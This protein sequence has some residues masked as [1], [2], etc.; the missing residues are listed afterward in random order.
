MRLNED[1]LKAED[2]AQRLPLSIITGGAGTGKTTLIESIA[3]TLT[4]KGETVALACPTGKA[5]ARLRESTKRNTSTL[6]R[7]MG[8][9]GIGFDKAELTSMSVI[10]D[11]ASMCDSNLMS[12]VVKRKP[13]RLVL[14]GDEAQLMPVDSGAPFHDLVRLKPEITTNLKICYRNSEAVFQAAMAVRNGEQ[15]PPVI[16]SDK[17]H[18]EFVCLRNVNDLQKYVEEIVKTIDFERDIIL[19]PK[20]GKTT[21]V[22]NNEFD[23][24]ENDFG[25]VKTINEMVISRL[26]NR[27][28]KQKW[29]VGD[30]II[31]LKNFSSLDIWNGTTG[32]VTAIISSGR[33]KGNLIVRGDIPFLSELTG[34]YVEEIEW[35]NDVMQE[36]QHAYALTIHKSQGSQYDKVYF[37]SRAKDQYMFTRPLIYTA[38]TRARKECRVIGD[39]FAMA[40]GISKTSEKRTVIQELSEGKTIATFKEDKNCATS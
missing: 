13:S 3:N 25:T 16:H 35:P 5:A 21:K 33:Q 38:L 10:I 36:C 8:Y 31:C 15:P 27:E 14:V 11:E 37:I 6:H 22:D 39:P 34:E 2:M 23:L 29:Q 40:R 20:N 9:N 18:Y 32:T 19:C 12:S 30:R 7:L 17:E 4:N 28:E 1:Q 26:N 24:A